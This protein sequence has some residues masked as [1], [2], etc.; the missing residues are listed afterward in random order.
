M[1]AEQS[2]VGAMG[3]ASWRSRHRLLEH[4]SLAPTGGTI[5]GRVSPVLA[6]SSV[7]GLNEVGVTD[8]VMATIWRFGPNAA[9]F[10]I[11]AVAEANHLGAD[12]AFLHQRTSRILLYQAK[13]AVLDGKLLTLKSPVTKS[14]VRLLRRQSVNLQGTKYRIT[15][16]LALYQTDV[17]PFIDRCHNSPHYDIWWYEHL[18]ER[19][20]RSTLAR[21]DIAPE[22]EVGRRYYEDVLTRGCSPSG[23][24]AV[25]I[26]IGFE[27][28]KSVAVSET[29]PWEF[30]TYEWLQ[31]ASPLDKGSGAFDKDRPLEQ[32]SPEFEQYRPTGA[33]ALSPDYV[34]EIA[35]ELI[36]RL[37]LPIGRQL[38][39]VALP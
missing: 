26:G 21:S 8:L 20:I 16:R 29:W 23:V 34:M 5:Q 6:H 10:A 28:I 19:R 15:G 17:T 30:D 35:N 18:L 3:C 14:Q 33:E 1:T 38:Y 4:A 37:R 7:L 39:L 11:S 2:L 32:R 27:P 22:P 24:L 25:G 12:I 36:D 31:Q 13:L 9:A